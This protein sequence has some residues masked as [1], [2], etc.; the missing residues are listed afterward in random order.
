LAG[1]DSLFIGVTGLDAYQEQIDVISNN[2][3]N[4]GTTGYKDQSV[5]FQD[6]LYQ[7]QSFGSAPTATNGGTNPEQIGLGVQVGSIDTDFGQGGNDTTGV[8][9]NLELSGNGFFILNNTGGTGS[10]VYTRNGDFQLN[11][12]NTLIDPATGLAVQGFTANNQGVVTRGAPT[13]I[14]IPLGQQSQA[15]ATGQGIKAGPTGD[16]V[17]DVSIGGNLD[18]T[19]YASSVA[20]NGVGNTL[21]TISGTLFD[22]LGGSHN[23]SITFQPEPP[24]ANGGTGL[25][26]PAAVDNTAGVPEQAA[27][28]WTYTITST[29]GTLFNDGGGVTSTTSP[30]QFAF[31]DQNGQFIN[32]SGS[33]VAAAGSTHVAGQPPSAATG[34]QL[35][36]AQWGAPAG[37]NNSLTNPAPPVTGPIGIDLSQITSLAG[38]GTTPNV[39]FQNGFAQ[40][41][42]NNFSIGTDGT[43]TGDF[44]N[45]QTKTIGQ[46]ALATFQNED[47]LVRLGASQFQASSSSGLAQ[48]GA[49]NSG[50]F[51]Q[52]IDGSLEE[53][54][55]SIADEFTKMIVAQNAF[56]ANSKS[57]TTGNEDLQTVIG[58][59]H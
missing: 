27:T 21:T 47:G 55:V 30:P 39:T 29:D 23:V 13:A 59:I 2:L 15:T 44:T 8:N 25:T 4:V 26:L 52:I 40:G 42:L 22:S 32:T 48:V 1:V 50:T 54:N 24:P 41:T 43:I 51:G 49:A 17:F 45:G 3:A 12:N 57:I 14:Q 31:F 7:T 20:N 6:L 38:A 56:A 18:Q 53:S 5:N 28:E 9:T 19:Q 46:V 16:Q 36:V 33:P 58:L 10:P 37:A 11:S 34:D 35:S